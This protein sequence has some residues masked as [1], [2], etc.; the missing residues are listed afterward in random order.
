[1]EKK[2]KRGTKSKN[3]GNSKSPC[4]LGVQKP[5]VPDEKET[6]NY[7]MISFTDQPTACSRIEF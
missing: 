2:V 6:V 3:K 1:M 7:P 5:T 4:R